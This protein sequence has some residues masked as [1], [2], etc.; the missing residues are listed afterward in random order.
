[1]TIS[2]FTSVEIRV[3]GAD[4]NPYYALAAIFA[5]GQR[6]IEQKLTLP[7]GPVGHPDVS[8][9]D[10][11]KLATDLR[12]A[13]ERFGAEGSVA[14]EVLGNDFVEHFKGTREHEWDLWQTAVTSYEVRRSPP[15]LPNRIPY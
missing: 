15:R 8:P 13:T 3:P 1:M 5:L 9:A 14:R 4:I 10:I 6:G 11:P 7:Y 2:F 12:S